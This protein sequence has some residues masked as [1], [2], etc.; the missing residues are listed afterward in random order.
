MMGKLARAVV[1]ASLTFLAGCGGGSSYGGNTGGNSGGSNPISNSATVDFGTS[2]QVIRGFGGADAWMPVMPAAEANALFGTGANEIGLTILRGRIDPTSSTNWSTGLANA[3]AAIAAG[4]DVSIIAAPWTPPA[5][6]KSNNNVVMGSLNAASYAAYATYLESFVTYM[7]NGGVNLYGISMQNEPDAN[8]T[9]ESCVWTPQQM[10][11]WVA[12]NASVLTTKLIM[13]ESESFT[14]SYSDPALN[15]PNAVGNIGIIA[16]HLYGAAPSYYA[17]AE[18]AGKEVWMTEHYLSPAGAQ[19]A[20]GDALQA[21]SEIHNSLTVG[22]YNAY[23]WWWV[24]DWNPGTGVTNYGLVDTNNV[25]TYYGWAVAQFARFVRPGYVR[26]TVTPS[27]STNVFVSAY[28][29][30]GHFV[31]VAI[32]MN[33]GPVAQTL[34]IQNQ[35]IASLTPYQTTSSATVAQ[36]NAVSV[37]GNQFTYTLPAQSIV[38]FVQ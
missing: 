26:S 31:I 28:K 38:T 25:P 33:A 14:T 5:A 37:T 34:T 8:V 36:Q 17:K 23:V 35:N 27:A 24:A 18:D 6:M 12:Q 22:N 3:Q 11:S 15:D 13:P 9:Y 10:D 21:A 16:G 32:N 20:I 7:A 29:G 2:N 1:A 4:S 30:S 19:P